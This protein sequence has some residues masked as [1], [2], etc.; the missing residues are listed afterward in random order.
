MDNLGKKD[1]IIRILCWIGG[2]LLAVGLSFGN[3]GAS[4][5][6]CFFII[7]TSIWE[8]HFIMNIKEI[9]KIHWFFSDWIL[10]AA[11][12]AYIGTGSFFLKI[13]LMLCMFLCIY[14]KYYRMCYYE[15]ISWNHIKK[16]INDFP[17]LC[18]YNISWFWKGKEPF[19]I[20][21]KRHK[22]TIGIIAFIILAVGIF[23]PLYSALDSAIGEI[24]I[25]VLW[26]CIKKIPIGVTCALAGLVPASVNYSLIKGF[27]EDVVG[28]NPERSNQ[29]L[30]STNFQGLFYNEDTLKIILWGLTFLNVLLIS[31]QFN[32]LLQYQLY[33]Y[34][35]KNTYDLKGGL[36]LLLAIVISLLFVSMS[37]YAVNRNGA[38]K[39]QFVTLVYILTL[40]AM[41]ILLLWRYVLKIMKSGID[42][43]DLLG[44]G[45]T[46]LLLL[47]FWFFIYFVSHIST[48]IWK[49][50]VALG[51]ILFL[52]VALM[53]IEYIVSNINVYIFL[54]RYKRGEIKN[55][56]SE[57]DIDLAYL[58]KVGYD[59]I[60]AL[61]KLAGITL[62][63]E[64]TEKSVQETAGEIL[65][66]YFSF[67]LTRT[68]Q[69]ELLDLK[70][71]EKLQKLI[72]MYENQPTYKMTKIKRTAFNNL[73]EFRNK[74][75][76]E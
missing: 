31:F 6:V 58:D 21:V 54:N 43:M 66:D 33:E 57:E 23:L 38:K 14:I 65:I 37:G 39:L 74:Y 29:V 45:V 56:V 64:P 3:I 9:E 69:N 72:I 15:K 70:M 2:F 35:M 27:I 60:S 67:D 34:N 73:K 32:Y 53:P 12:Y 42:N 36:P 44:L 24:A 1:Y 59:S 51:T 10:L 76:S 68:E 19:E 8:M 62:E 16:A 25:A 63:Y 13:L 7:V 5:F 47:I 55:V 61:T 75:V 41:T 11:A 30:D 52:L 18:L 40:C 50:A 28:K 49:K 22:V 4:C 26:N 48:N 46:L 71:E 20:K 17:V